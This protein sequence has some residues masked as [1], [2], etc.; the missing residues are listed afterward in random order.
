MN[1]KILATGLGLALTSFAID[2]NAQKTI[3]QGYAT[4][5][6]LVRGTM[7]ATGTIYFTP[8]SSATILKFGAGNFKMI[9]TAK[10]DYMAMII[11]IPV[12]GKH[13][14]AIP[15]AAEMEQMTATLPSFTFTP[16]TETK[17]ISGF[18]CKKV[19]AK[20]DNGKSYDIW[21]TNDIIV[22]STAIPFYYAGIGG[23]PVQYTA[24][25]QGQE[26]TVTIGSVT[27]G[28]APIG[29]YAIGKDVPVGPLTELFQ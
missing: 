24:F 10:H 16:T 4:F 27:E 26:L 1:F 29:T 17:V 20:G 8:D 9:T 12:A 13:K 15:T 3:T 14:A 6:T 25:Q 19:I 7:P 28:Q 18:K 22:P 23:Y 11:D 21:V 2:A 5:P